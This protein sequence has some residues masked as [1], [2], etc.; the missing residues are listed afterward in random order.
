MKPSKVYFTDFRTE[1]LG[2]GLTIKLQKLIRKAG[3][4]NLDL[5]GKFVAIKMPRVKG[6]LAAVL[7]VMK[8]GAAYVPVDPEYPQERIQYIIQNSEA[9]QV[10]TPELMRQLVERAASEPVNRTSP[11]GLA[12][13]IYTS[14]ST[15]KPKGTMLPHKA[16]RAFLAWTRQLLKIG[17]NSR[18][19]HIL[20]AAA[21]H[22]AVSY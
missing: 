9:K 22:A 5:D 16:L 18:H 2:D 13:M 17:E 20:S 1:A 4:G 6:F 10:L 7:G 11:E 21:G 12:Y 3:I 8:A 14:G 15:G 19:G